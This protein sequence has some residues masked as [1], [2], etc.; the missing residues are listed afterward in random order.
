[1][2]VDK[3]MPPITDL[4]ATRAG[5]VVLAE[6]AARLLSPSGAEVELNTGDTNASALA[7]SGNQ[8]MIAAD[9]AIY[10][11]D[12]R[13]AKITSV[14]GDAVGVTALGKTDERF[15]LGFDDGELRILSAH[16]G[17]TAAR[18]SFAFEGTPTSAVTR[19]ADG[20][21]GILVAGF[22]NGFLGL[23]SLEN[24]TLLDS[25]K[26]HGP[27]V[28]VLLDAEARRLYAVTDIG[29]TLAL[30]LDVFFEGYCQLLQRLWHDVPV[31]WEKGLPVLRSP[32]GDHRCTRR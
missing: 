26:L 20:I 2:L 22:A 29:D 1:M 15:V 24:G 23:W 16:A 10:L 6:R 13:G 11:F 30:D 25:A 31:A 21:H 28:H 18:L 14:T 5:C 32:P 27:I 8:I 3:P 7:P 4:F 17:R 19:I 9:D 12:E